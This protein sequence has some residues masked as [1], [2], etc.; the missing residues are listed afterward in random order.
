MIT[1]FKAMPLFFFE[2]AHVAYLETGSKP[3]KNQEG[4]NDE[5]FFY[6]Y[7]CLYYLCIR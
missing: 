4:Q 6:L 1:A 5:A 2:K 3:I 7:L